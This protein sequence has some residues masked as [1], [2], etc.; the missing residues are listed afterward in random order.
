[1]A[2][3][4]K[5]TKERHKQVTDMGV[6]PGCGDFRIITA[7]RFKGSEDA[8]SKR[9]YGGSYLA[10]SGPNTHECWHMTGNVTAANL[11]ETFGKLSRKNWLNNAAE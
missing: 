9:T 3:D 1:M 6:C 8:M 2:S 10:C 4:R 7:H 5:I 11:Y